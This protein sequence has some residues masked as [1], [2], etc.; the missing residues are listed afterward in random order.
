LIKPGT[1]TI[2][3]LMK[4]A[5]YAT[6]VIGKWHLGLGDPKP[7]WNGELKPGPL[8]IGFDHCHLLPTTNDRVP[9]VYVQDHRVLNLDPKDP[10][11]VGDKAGRESS[12]RHHAPRHA[13]HGLVAWPQR[14]HPQRHRPHR[15][16]HRRTCRPL[17]R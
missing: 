14:H 12:H 6:A 4:Q 1:T 17:P 15:L 9:Q 11:W 5:G 7:D 3:S 13:A 2:A 16:L 8:E 10:L